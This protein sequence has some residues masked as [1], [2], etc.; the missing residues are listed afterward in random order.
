M[1]PATSF[2]DYFMIQ[3]GFPD[4]EYLLLEYRIPTGFDSDL[5]G[6]G[7]I[8]WHIDETQDGNQKT[9]Y[10]AQGNW[11]QN[12]NIYKVAVV[13]AGACYVISVRC[14]PRMAGTSIG[15]SWSRHI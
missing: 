4:Q 5:Y 9:G 8:L 10:P 15:S 6:S 1:R 2:P 12:G 7:M 13:Q 3:N 11:P 14:I